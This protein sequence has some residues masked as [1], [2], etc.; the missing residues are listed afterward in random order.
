MNGL[1]YKFFD[2]VVKKRFPNA[3]IVC[4]YNSLLMRIIAVLIWPFNKRFLTNYTT[5]IGQTFY[6]PNSDFS[7]KQIVGTLAHEYVHLVDRES[8]G[9]GVFEI[10]YLFPQIL[11]SLSLLSVLA[12]FSSW[13]F[14]FL[15]FLVFLAPWPAVFRQ[16]IEANGY[17][18]SMHFWRIAYGDTFVEDDWLRIY[19]ET[20]T[21]SA[22]YFPSWNKN[23]MK[24]KIKNRFDFLLLD[25]AFDAVCVWLTKEF[26]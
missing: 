15:I 17:A 6:F 1:F 26:K 24:S 11:A 18:M 16:N 22:Y 10:K 13:F 3:K 9:V 4:K 25:P 21:G 2:E 19:T 20:L 5:I 8:A 23:K 12:I 14:L 7:N